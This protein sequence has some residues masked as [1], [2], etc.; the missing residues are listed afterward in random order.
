MRKERCVA[1]RKEARCGREEGFTLVELLVV[2]VVLGILIVIAVPSYLG[3]KTRAADTTA[4]SIIREASSAASAYGIDNNGT[5]NDADNDASTSGFEGMTVALL[6]QYDAGIPNTLTVYVAKTTATTHCL[7][8]TQSGRT[9]SV[10]GP[11]TRPFDN[12]GTCT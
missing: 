1:A 4:Q 3:Y 7:A 12:N 11:G 10:L 8:A 9:W 6:R 2:L 5:S